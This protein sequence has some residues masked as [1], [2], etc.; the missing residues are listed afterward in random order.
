MTN[1]LPVADYVFASGS[2][3]YGSTD[4]GYIFKAIY[5]LF[6]CCRAGLAFNLL[7]YVPNPGLLVAYDPDMILAHCRT[8][9][10]KVV[11]KDDY[12]EQDFTVWIYR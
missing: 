12:D 10:A 1:N 6:E 8:L 11:F 4:A 9:S 5:K 7:R 3:N 2:L